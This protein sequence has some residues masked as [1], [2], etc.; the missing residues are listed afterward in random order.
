M[1]YNREAIEKDTRDAQ[2]RMQGNKFIIMK[3]G[4]EVMG[5]ML[6]V[7]NP[8]E[9]EKVDL[10]VRFG[11]HYFRDSQTYVVCVNEPIVSK[12]LV[13]PWQCPV[14]A[15]HK[16]L[17]DS[18]NEEDQELAKEYRLGIQHMMN[19]NLANEADV[20]R[21][22]RFTPKTLPKITYLA[23]GRQDTADVLDLKGGRDVIVKR[24][25]SQ[26][27]TEYMV[28]P[29]V[30]TRD[31]Q[32]S[33]LT[34]LNDLYAE[35]Q[36]L[37]AKVVLS[38]MKGGTVNDDDYVSF[39]DLIKPGALPGATARSAGSGSTSTA[40]KAPAARRSGGKSMVSKMVEWAKADLDV[41][42]DPELDEAAMAEQLLNEAEGIR[43][44]NL[45]APLQAWLEENGAS[46]EGKVVELRKA[47]PKGARPAAEPKGLSPAEQKLLKTVADDLGLEVD[48]D[49]DLADIVAGMTAEADGLRTKSLSEETLEWL[50]GQ[51]MDVTGKNV[52][53]A[54][55]GGGAKPA[56]AEAPDDDAEK[57]DVEKQIDAIRRARAGKK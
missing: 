31:V 56:P 3:D 32:K 10:Y 43:V 20:V 14:C 18:K 1:Q 23:F 5:R 50:A 33:I 16:D 44:R 29:S 37:P 21:I 22:L 52:A 48:L 35:I 4:D 36:I 40:D 28:T 26:L 13:D 7:W 34:K 49:A 55:K 45:S 2:S 38:L 41:D 17:R 57:S 47:A 9:D 51:G 6:P 27:D 54:A 39:R 15:V 53:R 25:G 24:T 11:Q 46:C 12:Y 8:S 30:Q 19:F 42:L